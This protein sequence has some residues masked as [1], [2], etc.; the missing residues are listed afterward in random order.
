MKINIISNVNNGHGLQ[1]DFK[2]YQEVL[3]GHDVRGVQFDDIKPAPEA[4]INIFDEVIEPY[5]FKFAKQN[6]LAPHAEWF[7]ISW[8]KYL[9]IFDLVLCKTP[10]CK[11]IFK[12]LGCKCFYSSFTSLDFSTSIEKKPYVLHVAGRSQRKNTEHI[13]R[14]WDINPMPLKLIVIS[15]RFFPIKPKSNI[16]HYK[17]ISEDYLHYLLNVSWFHLMPSAYEGWG[18]SVWESMAVGSIPIVADSAPMNQVVKDERFRVGVD[19]YFS[20]GVVTKMA[21]ISA[22]EV[23]RTIEAVS[24]LEKSELLELGATFRSQFLQNDRDFR[25]SF[26]ALISSH[27]GR[28]RASDVSCLSADPSYQLE[29]EYSLYRS[30]V[31]I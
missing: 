29:R 23:R 28:D 10:D 1:R 8:K 6:W 21:R 27:K 24:Q 2:L 14:A 15:S 18:H 5:F 30:Q 4:D 9:P 26:P 19:S 3:A 11:R 20:Q 16:I 25:Q 13:L 31:G 7:D 17:Q 12:D 22:S